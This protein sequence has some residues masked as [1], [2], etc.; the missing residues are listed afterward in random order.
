[1]LSHTLRV[2]RR[3]RL[4]SPLRLLFRVCLHVPST[5][6]PLAI[7][8]MPGARG[9]CPR[10]RAA[11]DLRLR[12]PAPPLSLPTHLVSPH[13]VL[14]EAPP[15]W[16]IRP[17]S[18]DQHLYDQTSIGTIRPASTSI[19]TIR[20]ASVQSDQHRYGGNS[21]S[22][23]DSALTGSRQCTSGRTLTLC[24]GVHIC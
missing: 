14:S 18:V 5:G 24:L 15:C 17:A 16:P 3:R 4:C 2:T 11:T 20:P 23:V 12:S 9:G 19:G 1:M 21:D 6:P 10:P 7:M 8:M 22:A 13:R